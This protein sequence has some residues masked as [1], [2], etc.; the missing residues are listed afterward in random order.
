MK[1]IANT[2]GFTLIEIVFSLIILGVLGTLVAQHYFDLREEAERK[3]AKATVDAAQV[4]INSRFTRYMAQGNSCTSA[5]D[6]VKTLQQISDDGKFQFGDFELSI[7][8]DEIT[9]EGISVSAFSPSS[10]RKFHDIAM[11]EVP[12]CV[13]INFPEIEVKP[14]TPDS[15]DGMITWDDLAVDQEKKPEPGLVFVKDGVLYVWVQSEG[16]AGEGDLKK[17]QLLK[18]ANT[19]VE[20]NQLWVDTNKNQNTKRAECFTYIRN[21]EGEWEKVMLKEIPET[22]PK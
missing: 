12:K 22:T 1:R 8:G 10:K 15:F 13:E 19:K 5:V 6:K 3:L 9:S 17:V 16:W 21:S 14:D 20:G 7:A 2:Q 4:K 18:D 11:L